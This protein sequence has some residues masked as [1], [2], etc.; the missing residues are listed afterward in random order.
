M[1]KQECPQCG[2]INKRKADRCDSCYRSFSISATKEESVKRFKKKVRK[3]ERI[4]Q[5]VMVAGWLLGLTIVAYF[6]AFT[7]GRL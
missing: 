3:E 4:H 1:R 6:F 7:L 5:L 2:F